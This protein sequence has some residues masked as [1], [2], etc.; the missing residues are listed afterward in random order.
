MDGAARGSLAQ[1]AFNGAAPLGRTGL[2]EVPPDTASRVKWSPTVHRAPLTSSL[3]DA[4]TAKF[5]RTK[6]LPVE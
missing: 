1:R 6:S 2:L 3:I 5:T 4:G